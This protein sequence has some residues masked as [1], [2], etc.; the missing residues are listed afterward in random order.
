[1]LTSARSD[2]GCRGAAENVLV[3]VCGLSPGASV[4]EGQSS[5]LQGGMADAYQWKN[6]VCWPLDGTCTVRS[7][8]RPSAVAVTR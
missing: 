1:M 6:S 7:I 3:L 4:R 8:E 2:D 5:Q